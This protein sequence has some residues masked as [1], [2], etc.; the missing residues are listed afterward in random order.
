LAI[1][2]GCDKANPPPAPLAKRDDE[3]G[4]QWKAR[5]TAKQRLELRQW[6]SEHRWHP[7]QL[8]HNFATGVRRE[9]GIEMAKIILGHRSVVETEIY[10]EADVRRATE[11][12]GA[13]G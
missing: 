2:R 3:T 8:R 1:W 7:H 12:M 9:H 10:A 11:I 4:K 5:L 6:R 13:I